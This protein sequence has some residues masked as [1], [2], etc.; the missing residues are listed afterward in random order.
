MNPTKK[1]IGAAL[2]ALSFFSAWAWA[3]PEYNRIANLQTAISERKDLYDLRKNTVEKIGNLNKEYQERS[4]DIA[5]ISAL[6]PN[7]KSLPE[8]VSA[9]EKISTQSGLQLSGATMTGQP[10]SDTTSIYNVMPMDI[11]LS[12]QY[13]S[14]VTMIKSIEKNLRLIDIKSID[15]AAG[16]IDRPDLLNISIKGEAYY[17]K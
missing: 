3:L 2:I 4:A 12:G 17:L 6:L 16:S 1:Y 8:V 7:K 14:L 13:P 10:S 15:A 11:T 5:K 9:I